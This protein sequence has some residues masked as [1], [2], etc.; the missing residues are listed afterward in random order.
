[1][2]EVCDDLLEVL[3]R[4][5]DDHGFELSDSVRDDLEAA[6]RERDPVPLQPHV[7]RGGS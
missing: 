3:R 4:S 5:V 6:V 1:M 2:R 7:D